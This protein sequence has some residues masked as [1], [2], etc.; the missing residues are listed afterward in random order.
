MDASKN[1][2]LKTDFGVRMKSAHLKSDLLTE[3]YND[4]PTDL[5]VLFFIGFQIELSER[6]LSVGRIIE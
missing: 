4:R 5:N 6:L 1:Y 3:I 2:P